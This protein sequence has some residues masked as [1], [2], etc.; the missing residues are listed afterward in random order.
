MGI[1]LSRELL[2][3]FRHEMIHTGERPFPCSFCNNKFVEHVKAKK[4]LMIHNGEKNFACSFCDSKLEVI[5]NA[6]QGRKWRVG[7][8]GGI[9][10][11][12]GQRWCAALLLAHPALGSYLLPC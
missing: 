3:Y 6:K 11:T 5:R 12:A 1:G 9:E 8:F 10:Y 2:L 4:Y 7:N